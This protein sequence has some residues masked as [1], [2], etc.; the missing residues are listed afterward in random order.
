[1]AH[2]D[3]RAFIKVLEEAGEL[4]R[5]RTEVD[6]ILEIT[7]IT[8]RVSK[9]VGPALL[10]ENPK[11][12]HM[13]VL[14]NAFGSPRRMNL[15]L[16]VNQLDDVADRI[17]AILDFKS[18]SGFVEKLKMLPTL[19]E[20]AKMFPKIVR[21][22]PCKEVI[23]REN[24][25]LNQFPTL[26]CWPLDGGRF[27]TMPLVFTKDPIS[28]KRNCGMYR[29]QIYDDHT[30]AM[31]WQIHHHGAAHY[32]KRA[33]RGERIEVAL[34][35]GADPETVFSAVIPAP[36]DVD[37]MMLAGFLRRQPVEMVRCESVDLEVPANAEI[38]VEGY[39][40]AGELRREGPFGDHTGF[41]S[42]ADEYPVLHVTC[43]THRKNP[44]YQTTIVGKPP[45]EDCYMGKAIERITLPILRKQLPEIVDVNMPFEGVFHN[46]III[47]I[48]KRYPGHARKIMSA[49]WGLG[50]A[51]L[52]KCIV[53]VDHDVDVQ[54]VATVTWKVLNNIDP[55]RDLQFVMGPVDVLD[56]SARLPTYGS[57][58]GIDGTRK[59]PEEGFTRP[60]PD[61]I[62]MRQEV[63]DLV[64]R[65][66]SSYGI[67]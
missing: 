19:A 33:E 7:E 47:S 13:P 66:W 40:N 51:M 1:M 30:A 58:M 64:S 56:H 2:A 57:K 63:I 18:P 16:G 11:G 61:E 59:W 20:L 42:L 29:I 35:I 49:I 4:R 3:L 46:L 14:I 65:K 45:M 39:V 24:F 67:D 27:I 50:Q 62:A 15:A 6:P 32:Q 43:I 9:K 37:E 52:A 54:N 36:D 22:G 44:I 41:Y 34:A 12:H 21:H 55:E 53:V 17:G 25:S 8:D 60:W 10:F 38:V 48:K 5:I 23:L 28:G 26:Q 31:H